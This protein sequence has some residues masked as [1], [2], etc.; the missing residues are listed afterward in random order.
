MH[1]DCARVR[2]FIGQM[3]MQE[4]EVAISDQQAHYLTHVM[5]LAA[6]DR[7]R[8]F[9]GCDGEWLARIDIASRSEF[10]LSAEK[11]LRPQAAEPGPALAFAPIRRERMHFIVEK[12]TELGVERLLPILTRNT[13]RERIN[14]E[15]MHAQ[16]VEAA[17]QCGR[18]TIP[19]IEGPEP[20]AQLVSEWP[21]SRGCLFM[22]KRAGGR[23]ISA[24]VDDCAR[25]FGGRPPCILVG[26]EGGFTAEEAEML[27]ARAFVFMASLGS[28]ILRAETAAIAALAC[29][30][31]LAGDWHPMHRSG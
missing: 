5:R 19:S 31:A 18:L 15:R 1:K 12:A 6:G 13:V 22:H 3:L 4:A 2:L 28:R 10:R 25:R 29:W 11:L 24:A 7:L 21:S 27:E 26:P 14:L 30:Q 23:L 16:A 9:N 17:E 8:I 20:L